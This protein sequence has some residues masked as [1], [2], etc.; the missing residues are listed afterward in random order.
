MK[1]RISGHVY[2]GIACGRRTQQQGLSLIEVAILLVIVGLILGASIVPWSSLWR[3]DTYKEERKNIAL[4]QDAVLGYAASHKTVNSTVVVSLTAA[5][6]AR[7]FVLPADRPYLPCPDVDGDGI[8]DREGFDS[9]GVAFNAPLLT[10]N[11]MQN[12]LLRSGN[13]L[14]G[15]GLL[16]WRTLGLPPTDYWGNR[17]TYQVDDVFSN[18]LVGFDKNSEIDSFDIRLP[19]TVSAEGRIFYQKRG[20]GQLTLNQIIHEPNLGGGSATTLNY[21]NARRP[22]VVC[23]GGASLAMCQR[24]VASPSLVLEAGYLA[25]PQLISV[26]APRRRYD[27]GDVVEGVPYVIVSH[28]ANGRGAVNDGTMRQYRASGRLGL[29]CNAPVHGSADSSASPVMI[30]AEIRH[31]VVN[32]PQVEQTAPDGFRYCNP[33]AFVTAASGGGG[34]GGSA[35]TVGITDGY[36]VS[37]PRDG[38]ANYDDIVVW[39]SKQ[40]LVKILEKNGEI[41]T[42]NF[43]V[44]REY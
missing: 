19:V 12:D 34:G 13:C 25:A 4:A 27:T 20:S 15:R 38:I 9:L 31:E 22:I 17:Y 14:T 35:V 16:P 28:G 21:G 29:I 43:P 7:Q 40:E 39:T 42:T 41:P 11:A 5:G 6:G 8:E 18:A 37:Q 24:G 26:G 30:D 33:P 3:D 1:T 36:F 32:F 44:L 23:S 2:A 10:I